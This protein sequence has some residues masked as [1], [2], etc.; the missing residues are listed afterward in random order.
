MINTAKMS[1][2]FL[3]SL[4]ILQGCL[5]DRLNPLDPR[6]RHYQS[7]S[8]DPAD[9]GPAA[10]E[11]NI[12]SGTYFEEQTVSIFST[13]A[14]VSI[15][16]TTDGTVPSPT[17]G[18]SYSSPILAHVSMTIRAVAIDDDQNLSP[19]NMLQCVLK[20]ATPVTTPSAG[21][22]HTDDII[23]ITCDTSN[24]KI[25]YTLD[26]TAP[27]TTNGFTY[28][29]P[30]TVSGENF[31]LNCRGYRNGWEPSE[32]ATTAYE[33][34]A[35]G[36]VTVPG[37]SPEPGTYDNT[38]EITLT[39]HTAG[40]EIRYTL[41]ST[42]P[43]LYSGYAY[44]APFTLSSSTT[45]RARAFMD[46][47]E[48]SDI[49]QSDYTIVYTINTPTNLRAVATSQS[50]I[51]LSWTDTAANETGF[52]IE[53][54]VGSTGSFSLIATVSANSITFNDTQL[55]PG[56][57]YYYRLR[58][59]NAQAISEY[60]NIASATTQSDIVNQ[61]IADHTIVANYENIPQEYIDA[62]KCMYV[63]VLG[64]SHSEAYRTGL[65][66]LE[67][68][69]ATYQAETQEDGTP[70]AATDRYL[71]LNRLYWNGSTWFIWGAGEAVFWTT[72]HAIDKMTG[73]ITYCNGTGNNPLTAIAFG[74]CWDMVDLD[75]ASQSALDEEH[76]VHWMG[77]SYYW[78]GSNYNSNY[79]A[80]GLDDSDYA[81]TG[82]PVSMQTYC[83]A[84]DDINA[85]DED[86]V[87]FFTTG[88]QDSSG[89]AGYQCHLKQEYIRSW[90]T[91]NSTRVLFDYADILSHN[92][93]GQQ[94]TTVWNG[95]TYPILHPDNSGNDTGHIGNAGAVRLA[96]AMWWML[97]RIA[98][99]DG[100]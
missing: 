17:N 93:S 13:D 9:P 31:S 58:S 12:A 38:V 53:R 56:T 84:I 74:W 47:L 19:V 41:D 92:D 68:I 66:L 89:E 82:N 90:V 85:H 44:M 33:V 62:V 78:N 61:I 55:T 97:A 10:P 51:T 28:E 7:T 22:I 39:S 24:T 67:S 98:G 63:Q 72:Q 34:I 40:A 80:W 46:G 65:N 2:I 81:L 83:E 77:R 70:Y 15:I 52:Q 18:D 49:V 91:S 100:N 5:G 54:R 23:T 57:L 43:T 87:C 25:L 99:W 95:H 75:G 37:I 76:G 86:T 60:S 88:P 59:F 14:D 48:D 29:I 71:R 50:V 1:L 20:V 69:N 3:L 8:N 30:I 73:N 4:G 6:S 27:T 94:A 16:F 36:K 79:G 26:G 21:Q 96:K 45:V 32:V 11:F 42:E 35:P 64:E